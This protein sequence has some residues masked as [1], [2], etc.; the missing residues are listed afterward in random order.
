M[1]FKVVANATPANV[2]ELWLSSATHAEDVTSALDTSTSHLGHYK[3]RIV[4]KENWEAFSCK[5]VVQSY[6]DV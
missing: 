1:V 4:L 3:N 5:E 6:P 2:G